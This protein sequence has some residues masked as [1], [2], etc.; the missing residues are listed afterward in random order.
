MLSSNC[1]QFR[2]SLDVFKQLANLNKTYPVANFKS[3][4]LL[5]LVAP[6]QV[7]VVD[8]SPT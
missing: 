3:G 2:P 5:C 8:Y 4:A 7:K 6:V 1:C